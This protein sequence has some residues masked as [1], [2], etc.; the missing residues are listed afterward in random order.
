MN[1]QKT[2]NFSG[3]EKSAKG[4]HNTMFYLKKSDECL[5]IEP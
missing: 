4:T 1:I 2:V 3:L 5:Q